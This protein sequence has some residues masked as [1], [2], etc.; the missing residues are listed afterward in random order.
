M[1]SDVYTFI[2]QMCRIRATAGSQLSGASTA[3]IKY[4]NPDLSE[5]GFVEGS[6]SGS[7]MITATIGANVFDTAGTWMI[8]SRALFAGVEYLGKAA[9]LT[10][11]KRSE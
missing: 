7:D 9:K 10:V 4:W 6:I 8:K 3:G 1:S 11:Y 5:S 2:N